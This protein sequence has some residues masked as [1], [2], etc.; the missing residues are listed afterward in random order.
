MKKLL[1]L[2]MILALAFGLVACGGGEEA[3]PPAEDATEDVVVEEPAE[4][5]AEDAEAADAETIPD[6]EEV[7]FIPVAE[8]VQGITIPEFTVKVN[9][10]DVTH[11]EMAAYP[12]YSVQTQTVNSTGT[13]SASTY[14]GFKITDVYAAAGISGEYGWIKATAD[15]GYAVEFDGDFAMSDV[16]LLAITEDGN[17]FTAAPWFAPCASGTTGDYLKG[18][19][20][21]MVDSAPVEGDAAEGDAEAASA[22]LTLG[23]APVKEDRTDKVEFAPYSFMI[24]GSEI[25]N[26]TLAGLSIYKVTAVT[27]NSNGEVSEATYT[28][29]VLSDVL[30]A[31]EAPAAPARVAAV[32]NDG[33]E[34]ELSA[35]QIASEFTI[36][37]IE[38]DKELGEE[39]TI[40]VAPCADTSSR[41]YAKLVVDIIVE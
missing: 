34:M 16:T 2:F 37:A 9:G 22:E 39:G 20:S 11:T 13:A 32:A 31:I 8:E 7:A 40:W 18:M 29:Y 26:E 10:T 38:K 17:P 27:E 23:A 19:V 25:N 24:N 21:L 1:A 14:I 28:G 36:I 6:S 12:L 35:E 4:E 33:Y 15:D 3:A 41:N 5:P 30:A